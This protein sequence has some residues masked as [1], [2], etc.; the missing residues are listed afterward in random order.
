[1]IHVVGGCYREICLSPE[2]A[3]FYGSGGRAAAALSAR[4]KDVTLHTAAGPR[5]LRDVRRLAALGGFE[6]HITPTPIDVSF[7]YTHPLKSNHIDPANSAH[8]NPIPLHVEAPDDVALVFGMYEAQASATARTIIYDPQNGQSPQPYALTGCRAL[9][10]LAIL[11]N[12]SEALITTG[13]DSIEQAGF[14]LL[15]AA[16]ATVAIIKAGPRGA[17]VF[18]KGRPEFE[19]VPA[20]SSKWVFGIGSGDVFAAAFAYFWGLL[21]ESATEAANKASK[22]VSHYVET[23]SDQLADDEQ[24]AAERPQVT[25]TPGK[26][27]LA[28]PFFNMPQRWL[29]EEAREQL[30]GFGLD[31]FSPIHDVGRGPANVVAEQDL[32]GLESCDRVFAVLDGLDAGTLFEVGYARKMGI[33][34]YTYAELVGAENSTMIDGSGC[35]MIPD[36][37]SA[38]YHCVWKS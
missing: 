1:M 12:A 11:M 21:G 32:R 34:V 33:P 17:L 8:L 6:A 7:G 18:T 15:D 25:Q 36:F 30:L 38:I 24:L 2:I 19:T 10:R 16:Q 4:T 5:S 31:V 3:Q 22:A 37:A 23:R 20:Y 28:G 35:H 14:R 13:A 26:V 9:E 29:I 27:Y